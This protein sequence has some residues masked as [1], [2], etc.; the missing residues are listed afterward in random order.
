M[1][2][3]ATP[4]PK[5]ETKWRAVELSQTVTVLDASVCIPGFADLEGRVEVI[6]FDD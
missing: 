1:T 6:T 3:E 2:A 4:E 5:P